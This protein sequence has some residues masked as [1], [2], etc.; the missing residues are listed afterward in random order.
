MIPKPHYASKNACLAH[1]TDLF[2]VCWRK[3][4]SSVFSWAT[5]QTG[6]QP[7]VISSSVLWQEKRERRCCHFSFALFL[8]RQ[9]VTRRMRDERERQTERERQRETDRG[10][11]REREREHRGMKREERETGNL[12]DLIFWMGELEYILLYL[13]TF[14]SRKQWINQTFKEVRLLS[15]LL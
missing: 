15:Q 8:S 2:T 9:A 4:A 6:F 11:K 14:S 7:K 3:F 5:F 13:C 12:M 1:L 10:P